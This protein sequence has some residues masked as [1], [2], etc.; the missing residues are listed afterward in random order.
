MLN[1]KIV[2]M[3][4]ISLQIEMRCVIKFLVKRNKKATE[5]LQRTSICLSRTVFVARICLLLVQTVQNVWKRKCRGRGRS[6]TAY[7]QAVRDI[8]E[9]DRQASAKGIAISL[10]ISRPKYHSP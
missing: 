4:N 5:I 8:I 7:I 3:E 6:I 2:Q 9:G 1:S 10:G